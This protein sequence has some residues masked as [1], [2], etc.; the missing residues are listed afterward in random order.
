[1][2]F[3]Y[4]FLVTL[5]FTSCKTEFSVNGEYEER[6]IVHFL[7]DQGQE[8]HFL[9]L[10]KTFLGDGNA[11]DFAIVPDSNYFNNVEAIVEEFKNGAVQ[12]SWL[13]KDTI[14]ENKNPG[15]FYHPEQKLYYFYANDLDPNALYRL[16]IDIENGKHTVYGETELVKD[17]NITVPSTLGQLNFAEANVPLNGYRTQQFRFTP[18]TGATF[19]VR[20]YFSYREV[21]SN[22][23]EIKTIEW[24]LG[25]VNREDISAPTGNVSGQG[26]FFYQLVRDRVPVD[27]SV[28]RRTVHSF[29][30]VVTAG[31][32]DLYTYMLVSQPTSTISQT[33]P[34]F[35][36]LEG[37][38]GIFSSR[39]TIRQYKPDFVL[40]TA[41]ALSTNS[42]RELCSG[43]YTFDRAFCSPLDMDQSQPWYCP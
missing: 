10:N 41:R 36:N 16:K 28:I 15:A 18:G 40:P 8:Y 1:M 13:L 30:V 25:N 23:T 34:E 11:F 9:K 7:L 33:K 4:F 3:L 24:N 14:I 22:G 37:A 29:E 42:T 26:E 2:R 21:T 43:Q 27:P 32:D 38:L 6:A 20:L 5:V 31:S 35:T 19:N 12:R 39:L 17:V